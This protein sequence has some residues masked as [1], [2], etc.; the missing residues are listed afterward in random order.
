MSW[1]EDEKQERMIR[2]G[3]MRKGKMAMTNRH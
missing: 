1:E 2:E 3:R